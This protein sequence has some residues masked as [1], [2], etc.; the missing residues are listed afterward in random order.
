MHHPRRLRTTAAKQIR[1]RQLRRQETPAEA[2]LWQRLRGRQLLGL[3]FRRQHPLCG[4]I[5]DFC[6]IEHGIII[7]LDGGVHQAHEQAAYD[8]D[9]DQVL[10]AAGFRVLRIANERVIDAI[11]DVCADIAAWIGEG[12]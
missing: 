2:A 6:C 3:K 11:D 10:Y 12:P 8:Q 7:E 9:R 5:V 4:F 1:A